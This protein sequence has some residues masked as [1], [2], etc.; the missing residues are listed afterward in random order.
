MKDD[1]LRDLL[2]GILN[3]LKKLKP[4]I[5]GIIHRITPNSNLEHE[6]GNIASALAGDLRAIEKYKSDAKKQEDVNRMRFVVKRKAAETSEYFNNLL[7]TP[8]YL[9]R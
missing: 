1:E 8:G 3:G 7:N 5:E 9:E 6:T 4:Q 2:F